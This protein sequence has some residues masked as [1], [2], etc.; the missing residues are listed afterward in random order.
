MGEGDFVT[1]ESREENEVP[2]DFNAEITY[3]TD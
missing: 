3:E 1:L 2:L